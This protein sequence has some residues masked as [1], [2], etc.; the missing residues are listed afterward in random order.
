MADVNLDMSDGTTRQRRNLLAITLAIIF[1]IHGNVVISNDLKM[2]GIGVIVNNP[3]VILFFINLVQVY[4]AWRYYQYFV[5]DKANIELKRQYSKAVNDKF[6]YTIL[7]YL[8]SKIPKGADTI[9]DSYKYDSISKTDS[10]GGCYEV[11]V[12]YGKSG[13]RHSESEMV[14]IPLKLFRFKKIPIIFDFLLRRKIVTDF[15]FPFLLVAY[16][17]MI[18]IV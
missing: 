9:H 1:I 6:D 16:S 8:G 7:Q 10:T 18:R 17:I 11:E 14:E 12:K 5:S 3:F 2:L 15:Y 4:F 13:T